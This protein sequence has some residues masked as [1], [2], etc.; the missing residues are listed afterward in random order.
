MRLPPPPPLPRRG[1]RPPFPPLAAECARRPPPPLLTQPEAW[2]QSFPP[3]GPQTQTGSALHAWPADM[4]SH[5]DSHKAPPRRP[6]SLK[7]ALR[8]NQ[9]KS[10]LTP[11]TPPLPFP[12]TSPPYLPPYLPSPPLTPF[13]SLRLTDGSL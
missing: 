4:Q 8:S 1:P 7:I 2:R 9:I 6:V 12:H 13:G 10:P 11:H 3:Q 5:R